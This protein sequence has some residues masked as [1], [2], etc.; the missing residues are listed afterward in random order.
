MIQIF[1]VCVLCVCVRVCTYVCVCCMCMC[2]QACVCMG[3]CA[4]YACVYDHVCLYITHAKSTYHSPHKGRKQ[5]CI[6]AAQ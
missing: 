6:T 4:V 1:S 3:V 5:V 2:V